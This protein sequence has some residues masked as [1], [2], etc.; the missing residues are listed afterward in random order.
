MR[1]RVTVVIP[2]WD[3]YAGEGLLDAMASVRSQSPPPELIVVDNHSEVPLPAL[4]DAV[5]VRLDHR[6]STG[7]ARNAGLERV[8]TP[9]VLFLD[10]DDVLLPGALSALVDG[11]DQNCDCSAYVMS[12]VDGVTGARHRAPRRVA[13]VLSGRPA[14][15]AMANTVWSLLPTQG[16]A[17]MRTADLRACGGY[18]DRDR[19]EDWVLACSLSF[20]GR[21]LFDRRPALCYRRRADSP[22]AAG[23]GRAVL[24]E[25]ARGVRARVRDD[26]AVPTWAKSALPL[27]AAG[28]WAAARAA[29]PAY[30]SV[31]D[32]FGGEDSAGDS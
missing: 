3:A 17:I 21:V 26:P 22:G 12:I 2:V 9:Y 1:T 32:W 23:V 24:L 25:N 27:I 28:Q 6:R 20:R 13:R 30:R 8:R 31:R 18:G 14:L 4:G 29:Y 7:A 19:G 10:A 15:F 16:A 11:L 5:V